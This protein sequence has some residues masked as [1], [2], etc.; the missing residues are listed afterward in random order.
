MPGFSNGVLS[1]TNV[2][3]RS[4]QPVVGQ[5]TTNG[6]L[7]IGSTASPNIKVG[8][9][10][11]TDGTIGVTTGSGTLD[12]KVNNS[13]KVSTYTS[14]TLWTMDPRTKHIKLIMWGGG[15]GGGSGRRGASTS[16]GGGGG[17]GA[18]GFVYIDVP[19]QFGNSPGAVIVGQG[20]NGGSAQ[21]TNDTDGFDG[22]PGTPSL[23]GNIST[24]RSVTDGL[25]NVGK[26]G[27]STTASGGYMQRSY[28]Q[29]ILTESASPC[30]GQGGQGSNTIGSNGMDVG[31]VNSLSSSSGH[32]YAYQFLGSGGGGGSGANS[33]TAQQAGNG[34]GVINFDDQHL[35]D[36][37]VGGIET[38]TINGQTGP[39]ALVP[40][41]W[42]IIGGNGGG[43]GGGQSSGLVAGNGGN[44]GFPGGGGGGGGGSLNGTNSGH[45]G[46]GGN[47]QVIVIEYF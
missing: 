34:G 14:N 5:V 9:P 44:G 10:T 37:G 40:W 22:Q 41:D 12:F 18:G 24:M 1:A 43:G 32:V 46:K 3:F 2:D 31:G 13:V 47:G 29:G 30:P 35:Q 23:F 17:G 21:T 26:G 11:G 39:D 27:T 20:G 8:T 6:Q 19:A 38:G 4:V 7:L 15:N 36:G 45:G 33:V 16:A 25:G 28:L 42:V